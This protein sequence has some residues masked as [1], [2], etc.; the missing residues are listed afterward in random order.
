[1]KNQTEG[2]AKKKA[3]NQNRA[4]DPPIIHLTKSNQKEAGMFKKSKPIFMFLALIAVFA[5]SA[6]VTF[7]QCPVGQIE[8]VPGSGVCIL[9]PAAIPKFVDPLVIPPAM[10]RS[11]FRFQPGVGLIDYY[12]IAVRQFEQQILPATLPATKVWSYGSVDHPETFNYPA[13][14]IEA[15]VDRPVRVKWI[16]DLVDANGV[17]LPH[18]LPVDPSLHWAN[19]IGMR[20][21]RPPRNPADP[22]WNNDYI[23][24]GR[25]VGPVPIIPH[26][27]GAEVT[28]ESD[29]FPEAWFLPAGATDVNYTTGTLYDQFKM[30][31]P[32][33][34]L[35][36][37]G[38]AVFQ[39]PNTQRPTTLWYH[40]HSLGMTRL[41]VYAGPA[42]FYLLRKGL[43]E[44]V[45]DSRTGLPAILPGPAPGHF[46][47]PGIKYREIPIMIQ[48]R[49]FNPDGSLFYPDNRAFFEGVPVEDLQIPFIPGF[50][51]NPN[52]ND[53]SDVPPIW[54][55][56]FF[57]NTLV[58]N[59]KTWPYL[60]VEKRQYRFRFLNA[61]QSRFLILQ[62][63]NPAARVWQIGSDGG[64]LPAPVLQNE[65]LLGPAERADVIVD[66]RNVPAG[67]VVTLL[68]FAPDEPFGGG[69]PGVDFP[70]ADPA[71]T[72]QVMEFRV[73]PRVGPDLTTPANRL[74]LPARAPLPPETKTRTLSLNEEMS[75]SVCALFDV[76]ADAFV[77]PIIEVPCSDPPPQPG[78]IEV[79]AF[80]PAAAKLGTYDSVNGI[81]T[82]LMWE[83]MI[84]ENP[85]VGSTEIWEIWNFTADAHPIHIHLV[86]F[87]V[88]GREV[89]GD[90][91]ATS[92]AGSNLP[93][94]SETGTKDTVIVY[95]GEITRVKAQFKI[96]GLFVWHCHILEHE[97]NEMMR[98]YCVEN[99]DGT[100][101]PA[102]DV[103]DN[104]A[105]PMSM[106]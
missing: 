20:D 15:K 79:A 88:L 12:E 105:M 9:D 36:G 55:P 75:M 49:S 82:P 99:T 64:F 62:L 37:P 54:N 106:P 90:P 8:T 83:D 35:W 77:V 39:Y 86:Q 22:Y 50:T 57:G 104:M 21:S 85:V 72:G 11:G 19:P 80:G 17:A 45:R 24:N 97:D 70:P 25:Y 23:S 43:F 46:D 101:D 56:E 61:S 92:I 98:P 103:V 63:N 100:R 66:F 59:G 4:A 10:P 13:Y 6:P 3:S 52:S 1:V 47:P 16:N 30:S 29:G 93:L 65:L 26:L 51:F 14:T 58:V 78:V 76:A 67:T 33:G 81:T 71:T 94:P 32:L 27:H 95:P 28:Q 68:N 18:L 89:Q 34:H 69:A 102:C 44:G 60:K 2:G 48:D 91:T 41:N 84:T 42:G 74:S 40:D 7:A 5:L 38:T 73:V 87:E 53:L 96:P 31:S